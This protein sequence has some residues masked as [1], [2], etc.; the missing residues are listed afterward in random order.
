MKALEQGQKEIHNKILG[1]CRREI[2]S[3]WSIWSTGYL[4]SK[5]GLY[6]KLIG[7]YTQYQG[8]KNLRE[9]NIAK[10]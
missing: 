6:K 1:L 5:V 3:K 4:V 9:V 8:N 7:K 10:D 2:I